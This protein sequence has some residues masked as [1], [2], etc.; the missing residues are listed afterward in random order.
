[1][2]E[3]K[4]AY[5]WLHKFDGEKKNPID[6]I[7][8]RSEHHVSDNDNGIEF[9]GYTTLD[10]FIFMDS[11]GVQNLA[12]DGTQIPYCNAMQDDDWIYNQP[13]DGDEKVFMCLVD[14][15]KPYQ[16]FPIFS[17]FQVFSLSDLCC[18]GGGLPRP[19]SVRAHARTCT[20]VRAYDPAL[21]FY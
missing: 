3:N 9:N 21:M 20:H 16:V 7:A 17:H 10:C 4:L 11:F 1:M 15:D 19:Q 8:T 12:T 18:F 2:I 6:P 13:D 14:Y 5:A